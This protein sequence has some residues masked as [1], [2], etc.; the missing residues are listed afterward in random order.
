MCHNEDSAEWG[1][2]KLKLETQQGNC[3]Y[4]PKDIAPREVSRYKEFRD[5]YMAMRKLCDELDQ[6]FGRCK[7]DSRA[8]LNKKR[9]CLPN[10]L[11][12]KKAMTRLR[13]SIT[14]FFAY[15]V[16]DKS[17]YSKLIQHMKRDMLQRKDPIPKPVVDSCRTLAESK[18]ITVIGIQGSQK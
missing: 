16:A 15:T 11:Q 8:V 5:Q 4:E 17:R 13:R 9:I 6:K 7:V 1:Y 12:L 3:A 2:E 14:R 10:S 18:T